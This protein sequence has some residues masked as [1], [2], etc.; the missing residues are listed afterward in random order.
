VVLVAAA[1]EARDAR[2]LH[3]GGRPMQHRLRVGEREISVV[4]ARFGAQLLCFLSLC[5]L[6]GVRAFS[7]H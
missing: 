5:R 7:S 1:E 4:E 6:S 2:A 3:H